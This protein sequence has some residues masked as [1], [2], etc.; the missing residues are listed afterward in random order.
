MLKVSAEMPGYF[1]DY[2]YIKSNGMHFK[3][4]LNDRI[5]DFQ[6]GASSKNLEGVVIQL[7]RMI[8]ELSKRRETP[9]LAVFADHLDGP[10]YDVKSEIDGVILAAEAVVNYIKSSIPKDEGGYLLV[11]KIGAGGGRDYRNFSASSLAPAISLMT[12][13]AARLE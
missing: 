4:Y 7:S 12:D 13:L 10:G 5:G 2:Q 9:G 1:A 6:S 8:K 3:N 11:E